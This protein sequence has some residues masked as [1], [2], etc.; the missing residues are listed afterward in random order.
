MQCVRLTGFFQRHACCNV[1]SRC[2]TTTGR[3]SQISPCLSIPLSKILP[4]ALSGTLSI[5]HFDQMSPSIRT[6][7]LRLHRG[8]LIRAQAYDL[9]QDWRGTCNAAQRRMAIV[10][11]LEICS[12]PLQNRF[13]RYPMWVQ[14]DLIRAPTRSIFPGRCVRSSIA[15]PKPPG[16]IAFM[17]DVTQSVLA[18]PCYTGLLNR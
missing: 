15:G 11:P 16:N 12:T 7:N 10:Q 9:N 1:C 3:S 2:Q 6:P 17:Q 13:R 5:S 4:I 14:A 8:L 18:L